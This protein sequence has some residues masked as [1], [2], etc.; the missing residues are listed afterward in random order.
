[1]THFQKQT[2]KANEFTDLHDIQNSRKHADK[3]ETAL[4]QNFA[5]HYRNFMK[6]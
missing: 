1:M 6:Y 4:W 5:M 3:K 2:V